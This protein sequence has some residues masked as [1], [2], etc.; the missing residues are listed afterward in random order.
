[1]ILIC[2]C[3]TRVYHVITFLFLLVRVGHDNGCDGGFEDDD[4][5]GD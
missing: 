3:L 4:G 1:M 2:V 5:D